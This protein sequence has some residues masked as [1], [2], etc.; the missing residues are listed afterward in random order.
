M[1]RKQIVALS[2]LVLGFILLIAFGIMTA[3]RVS[4]IEALYR[5]VYIS[6]THH[7]NFHMESWSARLLVLFSVL[8]SLVL[9]R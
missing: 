5:T 1:R 3:E 8:A 4:Y 7:D 2:L 9:L 6:L